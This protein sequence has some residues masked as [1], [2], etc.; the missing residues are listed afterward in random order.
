MRVSAQRRVCDFCREVGWRFESINMD[1]RYQGAQGMEALNP[2]FEKGGGM[3]AAGC[4]NPRVT[5]M[6]RMG[7]HVII[8]CHTKGTFIWIAGC[9]C[10]VL[11][12]YTYGTPG[13]AASCGCSP[14]A[15]CR[16]VCIM[17]VEEFCARSCMSTAELLQIALKG[18]VYGQGQF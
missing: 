5:C 18:V 6:N 9:L 7:K 13:A 10:I 17:H 14:R 1:M 8:M 16:H 4:G 2:H 3:G 15:A 12:W 11:A